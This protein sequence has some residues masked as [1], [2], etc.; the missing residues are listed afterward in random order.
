MTGNPP[1]GGK[2]S[3]KG[4]GTGFGKGSG[5]GPGTGFGKGAGK[6]VGKGSGRPPSP[7]SAEGKAAASKGAS[8][9]PRSGA[10]GKTRFGRPERAGTGPR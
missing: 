3:G 4:P 9:G 7:K 2:G 8:R 6:S 1:R 10:P 5:K